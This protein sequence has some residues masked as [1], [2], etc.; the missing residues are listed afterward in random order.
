[1]RHPLFHLL[2]TRPQLLAD[3]VEACAALVAA[4]VPRSAAWKRDALFSA[5]A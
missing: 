1:M 3:H 4:E 2:A 5:L